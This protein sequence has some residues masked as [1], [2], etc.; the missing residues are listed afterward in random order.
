LTIT[1]G[2]GYISANV[3]NGCSESCT[4][5]ATAQPDVMLTANE[6]Q[7]LGFDHWTGACSGTNR[8]CHVDTRQPLTVGAVFR[9]TA[10][11]TLTIAR[12]AGGFIAST[13]QHPSLQCGGSYNG[14]QGYTQCRADYRAGTPVRL[15]FLPDTGNTRGTWGG[16]CAPAGS[17]GECVVVMDGDK[18][19]TATMVP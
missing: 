18:T 15:H 2:R 6:T 14:G 3:G 17:A 1:G 11:H 16:A 8:V 12:P 5:T 9:S 13:Q 19:V 7:Q 10:T 4:I